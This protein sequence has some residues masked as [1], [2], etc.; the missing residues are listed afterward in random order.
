MS[1]W[2]AACTALSFKSENLKEEANS[3]IA[4][5]MLSIRS[6]SCDSI[7]AVTAIE[8]NNCYFEFEYCALRQYLICTA[9][10]APR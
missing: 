1:R 4:L 2:V 5:V 7:P 8:K 6:P 3:I 10:A 9:Q